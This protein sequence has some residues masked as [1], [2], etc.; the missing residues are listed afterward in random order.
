MYN[1]ELEG[2][3][4]IAG[5]RYKKDAVNYFPQWTRVIPDKKE[6]QKL[7]LSWM[8]EKLDHLRAFDN[9]CACFRIEEPKIKALMNDQ[10]VYFRADWLRE[11]LQAFQDIGATKLEGRFVAP[12]GYPVV[13]SGGGLTVLL[14]PSRASGYNYTPDLSKLARMPENMDKKRKSK[15]KQEPQNKK[16]LKLRDI[17]GIANGDGVI[18]LRAYRPGTYDLQVSAAMPANELTGDIAQDFI[19]R[20]VEKIDFSDGRVIVWLVPVA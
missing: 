2:C 17:A 16:C 11:V 20:D 15:I 1:Y 14:M 18:L 13:L 12:E 7:D 6:G 5:Q 3:Q 8:L 10:T 4:I 19:D 9:L